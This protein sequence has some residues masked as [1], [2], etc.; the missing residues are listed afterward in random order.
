MT[1][2]IGFVMYLCFGNTENETWGLDTSRNI[3][4]LH[5]APSY[6]LNFLSRKTSEIL[7]RGRKVLPQ[8]PTFWVMDNDE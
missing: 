6:S 5:Y 4:M 3:E 2:V 8:L 7:Q 1:N